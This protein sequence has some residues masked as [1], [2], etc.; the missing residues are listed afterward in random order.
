MFYEKFVLKNFEKF[1][2]KHLCWSQFVLKIYQDK[3]ESFFYLTVLLLILAKNIWLK[4][5]GTVTF[6]KRTYRIEAFTY[7]KL[8]IETPE[9]GVEYVQI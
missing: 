1:I 7:S 9:Q 4:I 2:G 5:M 6:T 8:T 3:R